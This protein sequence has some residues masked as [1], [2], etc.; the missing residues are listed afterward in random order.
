MLS[1]VYTLAKIFCVTLNKF[2]R[3]QTCGLWMREWNN[4][5]IYTENRK[6]RQGVK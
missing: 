4:E 1:G 2:V 3:A 5:K 6:E